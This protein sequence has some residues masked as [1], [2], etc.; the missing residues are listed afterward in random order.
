MSDSVS[1]V[2]S[3]PPIGDAPNFTG[4]EAE[5]VQLKAVSE[6]D[7]DDLFKELGVPRGGDLLGDTVK[8]TTM[9][10]VPTPPLKMAVHAPLS[11]DAKQDQ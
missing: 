5:G 2:P 8:A 10:N 11:K 3:L 7:L 1:S 9:L 6:V 4:A